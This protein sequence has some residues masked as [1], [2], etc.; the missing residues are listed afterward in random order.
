MALCT[1]FQG[2]SG[3]TG[4]SEPPA[5]RAPARCM[6]RAGYMRACRSGPMNGSRASIVHTLRVAHCSCMSGMTP[7]RAKR[8]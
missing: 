3:S 2:N 4:Q 6:L 8:R 5:S 7:N 1:W